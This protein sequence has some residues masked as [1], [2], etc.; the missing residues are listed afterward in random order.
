M[1]TGTGE[2][3]KLDPRVAEELA[4][5]DVP[6]FY[7]GKVVELEGSRFKIERIKRKKLV[8]RLLPR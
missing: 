8:L 4:G 1:D 3:A 5:K 7:V 6:L 2:L